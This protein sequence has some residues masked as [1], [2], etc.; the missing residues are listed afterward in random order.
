MIEVMPR[1]AIV[2]RVLAA[3]V[4]PALA[5]CTTLFGVDKLGFDPDAGT[6]GAGGSGGMGQGGAGGS[7]GGAQVCAPDMQKSGFVTSIS[8]GYAHSCAVKSAGKLWCW[9]DGANGQL[10]DG[11]EPRKPS[12][13]TVSALGSTVVEVAAGGYH[14]CARMSDGTLSCWGTN[15]NGQLGDGT[16]TPRPAPASVTALGMGVAQIAAGGYHSCARKK[17]NTLWCWG[18]NYLGQLGNGESAA[19]LNPVQVANIGVDVQQVATG[20][21]HTCAL[22]GDGT[23]WCWGRNAQGQ[24]GDGTNTN[25]A[26]PV[27]VVALDNN[28][29]GVAAGANHTCAVEKDGSLWCWGMNDGGQLGTGKAGG[30]ANTPAQVVPLATSVASVAAGYRHT[31]A[32]KIDGTLWCWGANAYGQLG[33]GTSTTSPIPVQVPALSGVAQVT[34][35]AHY[36]CSRTMAGAVRCWGEGQYGELA[37]GT[38]SARSTPAPATALGATPITQIDAGSF[39]GCARTAVGTA[40]CWGASGYGQVGDGSIASETRPLAVPLQGTVQQAGTGWAFSCALGE[41]K[42]WCWGANDFGQLADGTALDRFAPVNVPLGDATTEVVEIAIGG[43]HACARTKTN[44]VWCWGANWLGQLGNGMTINA[45]LTPVLIDA[46]G[47]DSVQLVAGD[48]HTCARKTNGTVWCWGANYDG[49]IGD[50]TTMHRA[51]PTHVAT[52]GADAAEISADGYHSCARKNDGALW[53]WGGN[54]SGQIG[55]GATKDAL[56]PVPVTALGTDVAAIGTGDEHSCARKKDGTVWCWGQNYDG[57]LGDGT[58]KP[59][60][61]PAPVD[62]SSSAVRIDGGG[63]HSCAT[64]T[65]GSLW[66]WG[67]G[68]HGQVGDGGTD[69]VLTPKQVLSGCP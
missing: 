14:S 9:G 35:G 46:L 41:G 57:A 19:Q 16:R 52:L 6:V 25:R 4:V 30:N 36:T 64:K 42:V 15:D 7:G 17:D 18:A 47:K 11:R 44:E 39:H 53:C 28:V 1:A 63:Y 40:I 59:H 50:G 20:E 69:D 26:L 54:Y 49:A 10:G 66:C 31:C 48:E 65:D 22:K 27:Q 43:W 34:C 60:F 56:V 13:V 38:T 55:N 24:L 3:I 21:H 5:S 67:W 45:K 68:Y 37:D 29:K 61:V 23:L 32:I 12:G 33:D 62:G 51:L 58:L 2:P 8:L